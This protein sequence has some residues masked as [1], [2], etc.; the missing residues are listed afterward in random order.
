MLRITAFSDRQRWIRGTEPMPLRKHVE[1]IRMDGMW[2]LVLRWY[3]PVMDVNDAHY[4]SAKDPLGQR[5]LH[6]RS[7][8]QV[9]VLWVAPVAKK[10]VL[11]RTELA[12][13][14]KEAAQRT[15]DAAFKEFAS[16]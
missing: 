7:F 15:Y 10:W 13:I 1:L 6:I 16:K 3:G 11:G 12:Q 4:P 2:H 14:E 5:D 9:G 8:S